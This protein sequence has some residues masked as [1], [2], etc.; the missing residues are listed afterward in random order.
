MHDKNFVTASQFDGNTYKSSEAAASTLDAAILRAKIARSYG[1]FLEI[2]DKF[3][4]DDVEV[5]SEDSPETIR[6]K[7]RMR[8]FY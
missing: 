4:A 8:P 3:Y 7:H 2:F 6:G 1:E 5:S